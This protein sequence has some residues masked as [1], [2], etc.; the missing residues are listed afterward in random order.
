[1]SEFVIGHIDE[2]LL[3]F[4]HNQ[5]LDDPR[6][7]LFLFGPL[8]D[9]R[10]PATMRVGVVGTPAG[11]SAYQNWVRRITSF[12]PAVRPDA[13]HQIGYPGFEAAFKT[14]WSQ[15]PV[16]A[17]P[18]SD[19]DISKA[20]RISDRHVAIYETVSLFEEAI[21]K[22]LR[23]DDLEVDLWFVIIPEEVYLLGRP[24]SRVPFQERINIERRI[25][26][27]IAARL[28]TQPSLFA[29]D[30]AEA[31]I[32]G[33]DLDFHNQLKARLLRSKAVIQVVRD[34][35]LSEVDPTARSSRR[36]Q[37]PATIAWNLTTTSFFKAG[38]RPWK[39]HDVRNRVCYVGV[40][41]KLDSRDPS[42][43]SACC[44]AQMFLDSGDGLVFKGALGKWYSK[45]RREFHLSRDKAEELMRSVIEEYNSINGYLPSEVFIHSK[46]RF[47]DEEWEGF[48]SA[49]PYGVN[50]VGVK[51]NR[52]NDVKAFRSG[53][54]PVLRG[55][56]LRSSDWQ[57]YLWTAG[58]VPR[59][60]TYAGR[61]VPNPLSVEI[62]RGNAE[63]EAVMRDVMGL[64]KI[65]FNACIYGDGLPVTLRFADAVGEIL[66]AGPVEDLPP[67]PFRH[68][69]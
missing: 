9:N 10:K 50:V 43:Q 53:K 22:R 44:G 1:M 60:A 69:I 63:I 12:I 55:T 57:G 8:L 3:T 30:M 24:L 20:I 49:T 45:D 23:S 62:T 34:T 32:Y 47:N 35:S 16:V 18:I 64:T 61:E 68:Y 14:P 28:R 17:L 5:S 6:N 52:S 19:K 27:R 31:K 65:N 37:D 33:F 40:V 58:Y 59:L 67:L 42:G 25:D 38:G 2:P 46:T 54:S 51:I 4:G 48:Q 21:S 15:D 56:Y 41:F 13:L 39:L 11:I 26:A 7:G 29:E 66:T 36:M